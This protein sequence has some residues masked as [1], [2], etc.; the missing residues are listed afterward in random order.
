MRNTLPN[1]IRKI[2]NLRIL[3][4]IQYEKAG[5]RHLLTTSRRS[6]MQRNAN[7][8]MPRN[9]VVDFFLFFYFILFFFY[10]PYCSWATATEEEEELE[11]KTRRGKGLERFPRAG[12]YSRGRRVSAVRYVAWTFSSPV[13]FTT[14]KPCG[15]LVL[16]FRCIAG[17]KQPPPSLHTLPC[18]LITHEIGAGRWPFL[19]RIVGL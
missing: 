19:H 5:K 11:E 8:Q 14:C 13:L 15:T 16:L 3:E 9:T 18:C 10:I 17:Y 7:H 4:I 2:F 6:Q 12:T 1:G